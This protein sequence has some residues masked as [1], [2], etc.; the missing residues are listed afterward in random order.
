[1]GSEWLLFLDRDETGQWIAGP[2][3]PYRQASLDDA[4]AE[5]GPFLVDVEAKRLEA[6]R[7]R[8]HQGEAALVVPPDE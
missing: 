2:C 5:L 3:A 1:V 8:L 6:Y 4:V 7:T